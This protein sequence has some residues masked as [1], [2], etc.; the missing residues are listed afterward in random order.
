MS[1]WWAGCSNAVWVILP[2][3]QFVLP[4]SALFVSF[5][6]CREVQH[7]HLLEESPSVGD[8]RLLNKN[9]DFMAERTFMCQRVYVSNFQEEEIMVLFCSHRQYFP[10]GMTFKSIVTWS[11]MELSVNGAN[12]GE[13]VKIG[14]LEIQQR[15]RSSWNEWASATMR[16]APQCRNAASEEWSWPSTSQPFD[17]VK[18]RRSS[19]SHLEQHGAEHGGHQK[20]RP[21]KPKTHHDIITTLSSLAGWRWWTERQLQ[22]Q[23]LAFIILFLSFCLASHFF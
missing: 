3:G 15:I 19:I 7:R 5:W 17:S 8:L 23:L 6:V 14:L 9:H 18:S 2:F 10:F 20:R 4:A 1:C 16:L 12:V 11:W 21:N 13:R 22:I